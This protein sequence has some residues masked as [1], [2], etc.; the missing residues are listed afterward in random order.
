[1]NTQK[2]YKRTKAATTQTPILINTEIHPALLQYSYLIRPLIFRKHCQQNSPL[3]LKQAKCLTQVVYLPKQ[4]CK[5]HKMTIMVFHS[6]LKSPMVEKRKNSLRPLLTVVRKRKRKSNVK[7]FRFGKN[8]PSL[9]LC[10]N[11]TT[12]MP[13]INFLGTT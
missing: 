3:D 12:K 2:H 7:G 10:E 13:D 1:M 4:H 6:I 5:S 9:Q 11:F 8:K